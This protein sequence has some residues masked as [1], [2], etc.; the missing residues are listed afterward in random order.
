MAQPKS[1]IPR[2]AWPANWPRSEHL[3][4]TQTEQMGGRARAP[5]G[6]TVTKSA[7]DNLDH[8]RINLRI[9]AKFKLFPSELEFSLCSHL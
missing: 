7:D 6:G 3:A 8:L 2:E 9:K 1:F 5:E 4:G